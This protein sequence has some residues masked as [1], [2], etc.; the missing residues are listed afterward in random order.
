MLQTI[1]A[2]AAA[3]PDTY[4]AR[5]LRLTLARRRPVRLDPLVQAVLAHA[6]PGR[7]IGHLVAA[8]GDLLDRRGLEFFGV[9]LSGHLCLLAAPPMGLRFEAQ[10]CVERPGRFNLSAV[11]R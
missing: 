3:A 10:R 11:A 6:K 7:H 5:Q 8:L 1:E 2:G 9:S 4:A